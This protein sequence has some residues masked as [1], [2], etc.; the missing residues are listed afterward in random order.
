MDIGKF[1]NKGIYNSRNRLKFIRRK[2]MI[3]K[4]KKI[5]II[6]LIIV[7]VS[8]ILVIGYLI[9]E[10]KRLNKKVEE[11]EENV[12]KLLSSDEQLN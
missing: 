1:W 7:I 4:M 9:C 2:N 6:I 11:I 10:N 12:S 3:E 8:S 5:K